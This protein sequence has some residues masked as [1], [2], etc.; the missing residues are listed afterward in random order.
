MKNF[1]IT[2]YFLIGIFKSLEAQNFE[3]FNIGICFAGFN[4]YPETDC[5]VPSSVAVFNGNKTSSLNLCSEHGF[6][7]FYEETKEGESEKGLNR[8]INLAKLNNMKVAFQ[9]VHYYKPNLNNLQIGTNTYNNCDHGIF[10]CETPFEVTIPTIP[11]DK[12]Y[13]RP[14]YLKYINNIFSNPALKDVIWCHILANEASYEH[15]YQ[16]TDSCNGREYGNQTYFSKV[17][18]P[19]LNVAQAFTF[20]KNT[21]EGNN[22]PINTQKYA[23]ME[24]NHGKSINDLTNDGEGIYNP[25]T[26]I[27]QLNKE[28]VSF[29]GSYTQFPDD[30]LTQ[31][32][33][34]NL[35]SGGPPLGING[36]NFHY[37]SSFENIEYEKK[38]VDN[39]QDVIGI[40][41]TSEFPE[42][43]RHYNSNQNI[44]NANWLWFQAYTSIIH[45]V[46]GLW[47]YALPFSWNSDGADIARRTIFNDA[48]NLTKF[49]SDSNFPSNYQL[50]LKYLA[51]ELRVLVNLGLISNDPK[52]VLATKLNHEDE[53]C[54]VPPS[55]QYLGNL[56]LPAEKKTENY[57]LRYTI[58]THNNRVIMIITNPLNVSVDVNLDFQYFTNPIVQRSTGVQVYF[59]NGSISNSS[60]QYKV[61]RNSTINL[62]NNTIGQTYSLPFSNS[63]ILPMSFG[64]LDV[65]IF[66]FNQATRPSVNTDWQKV[67][68]NNGDNH[69]GDWNLNRNDKITIGDFNNNGIEDILFINNENTPTGLASL[70]QTTGNSITTIWQNNSN[71]LIG[72]WIISNG[73]KFFPAKFISSSQIGLFCIQGENNGAKAMYLVYNASA[74]NW[75]C[76]WSNFGVNN[77]NNHDLPGFIDGWS[78]KADDKFIIGDFDN[79]NLDE[80]MCIQNSNINGWA[81]LL[82]YNNNDFNWSWSNYGSGSIGNPNVQPLWN[83]TS[84][85]EYQIGD[86]DGDG[87][88]NE[89]FCVQKGG[90]C[91]SILYRDG[92]IWDSKYNNNCINGIAGWGNPVKFDDNVLVGNIDNDPKEELMFIQSCTNCQ[93]A[94]TED[95]V[96]NQLFWNWSNQNM[97]TPTDF[98]GDWDVKNNTFSKSR[99]YLINTESTLSGAQ[100]NLLLAI[101]DLGCQSSSIA[102]LYTPTDPSINKLIK[103]KGNFNTKIEFDRS[104][105][106]S[107]EI[108]VLTMG[109]SK[110]MNFEI[111]DLSGKLLN[112]NLELDSK[113]GVFT[114]PN[115]S[116]GLY[117]IKVRDTKGNQIII[118]HFKY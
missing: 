96:G 16:H 61:N 82:R 50:Y 84:I 101:R 69:I 2:S 4:R 72:P 17:E 60:P 66:E 19:P 97:P 24:A 114:L 95:L 44:P 83:I 57:G 39:V 91:G 35:N 15:W 34:N 90:Y 20:F 98:I 56:Q 107:N 18:V 75:I 68:T 6:N 70:I 76:Q 64:P 102:S 48:S 117:F 105:L 22:P 80:L 94:T 11:E 55:N 89:L 88:K 36:D 23:I 79:D 7:A 40:E 3:Q 38:Y 73:D 104:R 118:K 115:L 92:L 32:F 99:Y 14:H 46:K 51:Q 45:G 103:P 53:N 85:D 12:H 100:P 28:N 86:F 62:T 43:W 29:E 31:N 9:S 41:G 30:W 77:C 27:Q 1:I 42:G 108:K 59:N 10:E 47:F 58:R 8:R 74:N 106:N 71:G 33:S 116:K 25:Q 81:T 111:Y 49:N 54:I 109:D 37:L 26:Y 112:Y 5:I 78:I 113:E 63:K 93:F 67:W 52:S 65:Q 13:F 110:I 21:L 87:K